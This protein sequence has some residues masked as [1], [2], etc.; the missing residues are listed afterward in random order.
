MNLHESNLYRMLEVF[1][2][3]LILNVL[4]I[5]SCIPIVTVYPATA[6]MFGVVSEWMRQD[7]RRVLRRYF[8]LLRRDF[9]QSFGVGI[10]W[11]S[12]GIIIGTSLLEIKYMSPVLAFPAI[13]VTSVIGLAYL[14]TSMFLFPVLVTFDLRWIQ[15][16]R[17]SF[18]LAMSFPLIT[19]LCLIVIAVAVMIIVTIPITVIMLFS[20]VSYVISWLCH[21]AFKRLNLPE[22]ADSRQVQ[23][24]DK[25]DLEGM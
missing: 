16:L 17:N 4:W 7:E 1:S 15:I 6:A 19:I 25:G 10:I 2:N 9:A 5:L 23:G 18:L 8:T 24:F 12:I 20:T 14:G 11:T 3:L 13:L 22:K 21:G